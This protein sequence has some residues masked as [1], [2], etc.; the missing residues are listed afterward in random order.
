MLGKETIDH[1]LVYVERGFRVLPLHSIKDGLCTCGEKNCPSPGKHPRTAHGVK[2]VTTDLDTARRWWEKW[3]NSNIGVATGEPLIVLN[4]DLPKGPETLKKLAESGK[5]V[6]DTWTQRTGSGGLQY[7]FR[8][9]SGIRLGN[10]TG[11][12]PGLDFKA[13]DGYVVV[14][15][16][17]H[18]SGQ[19]Y[20]WI[21]LRELAAAPDW[22]LAEVEKLNPSKAIA[23]PI[24][25]SIEE[26]SRNDTLTS[27][28]GS[29]R[30]RGASEEVILAALVT[31]NSE[32][33][34]PPLEEDEVE[35]IARSV[36]GYPTGGDGLEKSGNFEGDPRELLSSCG[37]NQL[38]DEPELEE[39]Q[40]VLQVLSSEWPSLDRSMRAL[41]RR[42]A[43]DLL[44]KKRVKG[45]THIV[46]A[47]L[48][49]ESDPIDT[50]QGKTLVFEE[51]EPWPDPVDG[52][53]LMSE[54]AEVVETFVVTPEHVPIAAAAFALFT[55]THESF[56][57]SPVLFITSPE[58]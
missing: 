23:E 42:G 8:C 14:P 48:T 38:S 36:A 56:Q 25:D 46:D 30:Q 9:P 35:G 34:V 58:K 6:P 13:H 37:F 2:D 7:F 1:A 24:P 17:K 39:I 19:R 29:M 47:F 10:K 31:L 40:R 49:V 4:V 20:E 28:A 55:Y 27:F 45:P 21:D 52:E 32:I 57:T 5:L 12:R 22:L 16:S 51:V 41:V 11:F 18:V 53:Q 15:P 50:G 26:G 44:T 54:I 3:P 43:I 33:C